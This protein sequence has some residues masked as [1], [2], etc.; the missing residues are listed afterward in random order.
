M[1]N[2]TNHRSLERW[3][4]CLVDEPPGPS[5]GD[6]AEVIESFGLNPFAFHSLELVREY[7]VCGDYV[8]EFAVVGHQALIADLRDNYEK[9]VRAPVLRLNGRGG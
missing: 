6:A 1:K 3:T 2:K 4:F 7:R 8:T 5:T 9:R